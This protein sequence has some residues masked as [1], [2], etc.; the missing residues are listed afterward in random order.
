MG[1]APMTF[2]KPQ[3]GN[4]P[5][6]RNPET[7]VY[8]LC[9]AYS[10]EILQPQISRKSAEF[11]RHFKGHFSIGNVQV[12]ILPGQPGS[13]PPGDSTLSNVRNARQWRAFANW[14]SV[15]RLQ[16]WPLRERNRR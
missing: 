5:R 9:S 3:N 6:L 8:L 1:V 13:P 14:L 10:C 15:S 4:G 12:R 2:E 7:G 16:N 11:P